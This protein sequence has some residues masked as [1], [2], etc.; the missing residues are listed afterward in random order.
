MAAHALVV[1]C[2]AYPHVPDGDLTGAVGDARAMHAWLTGAGGVPAE[3]SAL[4][5]SPGRSR[6]AA[7]IG[8]LVARTDVESDRLYVYFAGHGG[9]TDPLNPA[10]ATDVLA[11]TDFVG[12]DP[13]AGTVGVDDLLRRL[14]LSRFREVVVVLDACRNFPFREPFQVGGIGRDPLTAGR[15]TPGL[16]LLQ[17]TQPGGRARG[18]G[19]TAALLDGLA[20]RDSAKRYLEDSFL[21]YVVTWS[22]LV[23]YVNA[24]LRDQ[25][26]HDEGAARDPVLARFPEGHFGPVRLTVDVD[27]APSAASADLLVEVSHWDPAEPDAVRFTQPGPTP[28]RFTVPPR[29]QVVKATH[30]DDWGRVAVDVYADRHVMLPLRARSRF[31]RHFDD[32]TRGARPG[33]GIV[34]VT[35][36]D[37]MAA[38]EVRTVPGRPVLAGLPPLSGD[39]TEG[40]YLVL[41]TDANGRER[42]EPLDVMADYETELH[43]TLPHPSDRPAAA[44]WAGAAARLASDSTGDVDP[45]EFVCLVRGPEPS[46]VLA[47]QTDGFIEAVFR[48]PSSAPRFPTGPLTTVLELRFGEHRLQ[49]PAVP[50]VTAAVV[51]DDARLRVA[52]FDSA[53]AHDEPAML[54]LDRAQRLLAAGRTRA[55]R[56]VLG[57]RLPH[58]LVARRLSRSLEVADGS[59]RSPWSVHLDPPSGRP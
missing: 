18:G 37:P 30:G 7:E 53:L 56:I 42:W 11:F 43:L 4:L 1:G 51:F 21:P 19:L 2:D 55:A 54:V 20:G 22:S 49:L 57:E 52:Y 58:S 32:P 13:S 36:D 35:A 26:P 24:R 23:A 16:Y 33:V 59:G 27:P 25:D 8:R 14:R 34:A 29:R 38:I 45:D 46:Q 6:F 39:L 3:N 40:Q 10:L 47:H 12:A 50:G 5:L 15:R 31:L 28:A 9:R 48:S 44:S 41:V 17:A